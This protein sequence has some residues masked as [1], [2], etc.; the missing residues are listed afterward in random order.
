M[1]ELTC[2][3]QG[4]TLGV[5]SPEM[6]W[7]K[8][9]AKSVSLPRP[10]AAVGCPSMMVCPRASRPGSSGKGT[11]WHGH[12]R[13]SAGVHSW[14]LNGDGVLWHTV[15]TQRQSRC[16]CLCFVGLGF[17]LQRSGGVVDTTRVDL[18]FCAHVLNQSRAGTSTLHLDK[19][20]THLR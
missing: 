14:Y 3:Q 9:T 15:S 2:R 8:I 20:N 6:F 4:S 10:V 7:A 5:A 17:V 1:I 18:I 19:L 12:L 16:L 13:D 11:P